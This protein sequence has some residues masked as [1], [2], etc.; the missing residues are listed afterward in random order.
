M[1]LFSAPFI[2]LPVY[3][4]LGH[5]RFPGYVTAR[6]SS[7][8]VIRAIKDFGRE[9][10]ARVSDDADAGGGGVKAFENL[11]EMT[12]V[13]G[14]ATRLLVDGDATFGAI[15]EAI[16]NARSY[17]LIQFYI[18]RDDA[19]GQ[20]LKNAL[21]E[22]ARAGCRVRVLYDSIGSHGLGEDYIRELRE[23]GAHIENFHSIHQPHSRLQINFRNHRKIVVIDGEVGFVGGLNVGD[24]YMGR[25][26][27][28][29]RW[30]DTHLRLAG[31]VVA[32]L[33]LIFAEDWHWATEERLELN[34]NPARQTD[35]RDA[36]I[37]ATGPAD[38]LE[39]GSL[40]FCNVINAATERVWIAS[41]YFVPDTDILR[42]MQLAALRG[43]DVRI[44]VAD[45]RDHLFVWLAAFAYFDEV[46]DAGV[47]IWRYADGFMH[48]KV[49]VV[50]DRFASVGT[51]NLDNRSCRLNFEATAIVFDREFVGEVV[52][53]LEA[54]FAQSHLYETRLNDQPSLLKKYGAP[55]ARLTAPL[56]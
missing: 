33:Q 46:R 49:V 45:K 25:D 17:V 53:M 16:G 23:A 27:R 1:F 34:W 26:R 13:S 18:L 38:V 31:P 14:N 54:D 56:L 12:V 7:H 42:T 21:V 44:L 24:E 5:S 3:L 15:L 39:T 29:G 19:I 28:F 35:D 2:A 22:R 51:V 20:D 47:R 6:R 37:L 40:Y 52:G 4:F 48:Q 9:H 32:Q 43:V 55:L 8:R 10:R 41:P 50:D 36:L 30:R 11:A